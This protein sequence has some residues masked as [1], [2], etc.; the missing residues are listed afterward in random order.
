MS[1]TDTLIYILFYLMPDNFT[2]QWEPL[3]SSERV[4]TTS[5]FTPKAINLFT[6]KSA[7]DTYRFY[8]LT[9]DNF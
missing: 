6:P 3:L 9:P 4:T 1:A 8:C 5:R 7:T 2:R